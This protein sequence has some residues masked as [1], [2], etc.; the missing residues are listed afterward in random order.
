MDIP[1]LGQ[2][3]IFINLKNVTRVENGVN[4]GMHWTFH[5]MSLEMSTSID[6]L[7]TIVQD[8]GRSQ[9]VFPVGA[10]STERDGQGA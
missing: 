8:L 9:G 10:T 4:R 2:A 6:M 5:S 3:D 1:W 7:H